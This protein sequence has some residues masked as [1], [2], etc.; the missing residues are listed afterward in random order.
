MA[1]SPLS[2]SGCSPAS[3]SSPARSRGTWSC[4]PGRCGSRTRRART[5]PCGFW[6]PRGANGSVLGRAED[7]AAGL[8]PGSCEGDADALCRDALAGPV[9]GGLGGVVAEDARSAVGTAGELDRFK[10]GH[11]GSGGDDCAGAAHA[12]GVVRV[13]DAEQQ[14]GPRFA[15]PPSARVISPVRRGL[16][17]LCRRRPA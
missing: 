16:I 12:P 10:S 13:R 4:R 8:R 1:L 14:D 2:G 15:V 6:R 5:A 3:P 11:G 9:P 7:R 17:S